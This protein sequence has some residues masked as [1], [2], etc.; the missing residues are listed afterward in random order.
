[1]VLRRHRA[2]HAHLQGH[3][4]A[5]VG[6]PWQ[7]QLDTALTHRLALRELV[8]PTLGRQLGPLRVRLRSHARHHHRTDQSGQQRASLGLRS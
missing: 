1:M 4:Q 6:Q 2:G 5:V 3:R 7:S 8:D